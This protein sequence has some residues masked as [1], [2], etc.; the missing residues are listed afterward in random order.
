MRLTFAIL[1]EDFL[2]AEREYCTLKMC[3]IST[4]IINAKNNMPIV[5][6]PRTVE[7]L[8][9]EWDRKAQKCG[10]RHTIYAVNRDHYT[11]EWLDNLKHGKGT[12]TWKSTGAIYNGDWKFGK[13]DGYGTYSIPDPLTKEY[14][15]VYSGWWKNDKKCGYGIKFYSDLEYYEGEWSSGKRSGWGRMYYKDG[16]IYEGQWLEDQHSGQGMLRLTNENRYEGTWKDGKKHGLGKFFYL[17]KGQLF[18]G[19]W[20]ADIP[21]CGTMIDFGREEVPT[22]TQ[23]PIPKIELANPDDVLEE[24][25]AML[26]NSQE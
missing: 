21:K 9:N 7:P 19:F 24:A 23:Y 15:K 18:E 22:P 12:Q 13:R 17:N 20:V 8:W 2:H 3:P 4:Y 1:A 5:K 25:Q 14:K 16:S 6:Y 11:G 10:L 26:D